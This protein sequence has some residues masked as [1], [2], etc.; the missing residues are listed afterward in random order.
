MCSWFTFGG[1]SSL[2][3][4]RRITGRF[5]RILGANNSHSC[6]LPLPNPRLCFQLNTTLPQETSRYQGQ[7]GSC[8]WSGRPQPARMVLRYS[9]DT[10]HLEARGCWWVCFPDQG[11]SQGTGH[12]HP[13]PSVWP[14]LCLSPL[15]PGLHSCPVFSLWGHSNMKIWLWPPLLTHPP[16]L[17][18]TL[19]RASWSS[20]SPRSLHLPHASSGPFLKGHYSLPGFPASSPLHV[21]FPPPAHSPFHL[22]TCES[23]PP[24]ASSSRAAFSRSYLSTYSSFPPFLFLFTCNWHVIFIRQSLRACPLAS[25]TNILS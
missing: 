9:S 18:I 23:S 11:F 7:Q 10:G 13:T 25:L 8:T 3:W 14:P 17:P 21:Q 24:S 22:N 5:S 19:R 15:P 1:L 20:A 12:L 4:A 16:W 6:W 2:L